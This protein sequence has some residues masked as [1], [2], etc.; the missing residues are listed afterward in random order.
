MLRKDGF[1]SI[2]ALFLYLKNRTKHLKFLDFLLVLLY[3]IMYS[4]ISKKDRG[5]GSGFCLTNRFVYRYVDFRVL[6]RF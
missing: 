4:K 6:E 2:M 1:L 3:N 5:K